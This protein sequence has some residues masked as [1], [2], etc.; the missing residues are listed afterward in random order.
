MRHGAKQVGTL[1]PAVEKLQPKETSMTTETKLSFSELS[2]DGKE[3]LTPRGDYLFPDKLDQG[4]SAYKGAPSGPVAF[5]D[6]RDGAENPPAPRIAKKAKAAKPA[7][8]KPAART[9]T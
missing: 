1:P 6:E 9:T 2:E 4:T 8:T 5:G 7:D 3:A